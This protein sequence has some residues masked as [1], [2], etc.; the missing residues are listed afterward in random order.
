MT[1][2]DLNVGGTL[3][4]TTCTAT[5]FSGSGAGLTSIPLS[6]LATLTASQAVVTNV[7]GVLSTAPQIL[8]TQGGTSIDSSGLTGIA[9]INVGVWSASLI[10]NSDVS[11]SAAI[12]F[13]K[14]AALTASQVVVSSAGGIITT[15]AFL[16][17]NLG[18]LGLS[19]A[20]FTG[21]GKVS[22][23]VWS[24]SQI[25]DADVSATAAITLSKLAPLTASQAIISNASG[26]L[27]SAATISTTLGGTGQNLSAIVG[28]SIITITSGVAAA[29]L[30]Y[31]TTSTA[32]NLVQRDASSNIFA[33]VVNATSINATTSLNITS[34]GSGQ[35]NLGVMPLQLAPVTITGGNTYMISSNL[36][37]T[38]A[39]ITAIYTYATAS[40]VCYIFQVF[41]TWGTGSANS[42]VQTFYVKAKNTAGTV[43]V[44]ALGSSSSTK[45][46]ALNTSS[47][48]ASASGTNVL[49]N[50]NGIAATTITWCLSA[51][52]TTQTF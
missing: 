4:C 36:Q 1:T 33:N 18:G 9:H 5:L 11:N 23:G 27:I 48:T 32:S 29:T 15:S 38:N 10:T 25:L 49:I 6:A 31:S 35:V 42:A 22:A 13:S 40:N 45:D 21:I 30:G 8:N 52:V 39:T 47:V 24:A 12:G 19:S 7:S 37:T 46:A 20:A 50:A 28:P 17:T 44:S 41:C 51:I 3:S 34:S 43:V 2:I 26:V 14:M 16:A